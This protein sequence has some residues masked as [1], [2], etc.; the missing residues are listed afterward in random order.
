MSTQKYFSDFLDKYIVVEQQYIESVVIDKKGRLNIFTIGGRHF[1]LKRSDY[2]NYIDVLN[3]LF[4][5]NEE[6]I[7]RKNNFNNRDSKGSFVYVIYDY[8]SNIIRNVFVDENRCIEVYEF[9]QKQ[10]FNKYLNWKAINLKEFLE[11]E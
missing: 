5:N 8:R 4:T 3:V 2:T 7:E 1:M 9:L 10:Q 6:C 11:K